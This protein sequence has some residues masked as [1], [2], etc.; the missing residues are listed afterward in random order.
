MG[1]WKKGKEAEKE[2]QGLSSSFCFYYLE[3][4]VRVMMTGRFE[5][6]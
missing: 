3:L 6:I 1:F 4:N 5:N 2:R